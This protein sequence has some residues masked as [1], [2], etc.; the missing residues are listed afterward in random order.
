ME[1]EKPPEG[2]EF[3]FAEFIREFG[4]GATNKQAGVKLREVVMACALTGKK[5]SLT[6]SIA[7]GA[8]G[9]LA[10]LR[11]S[12]KTT[13]PEPPLPGGSYFTTDAGALANEDP[14]QLTLPKKVLDAA[15]IRTINIV[16][17]DRS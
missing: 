12:V 5:G 13:K 2:D 6:I 3:D 11:A 8:G 16:T 17:G 14:R 15:P 10:E 1:K 7:I 9:G 4:H